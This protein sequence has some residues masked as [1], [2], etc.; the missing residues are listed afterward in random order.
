MKKTILTVSALFVIAQDLHAG[1]SGIRRHFLS[2]GPGAEP[3][4][5]AETYSASAKGSLAMYYNPAGLGRYA[6]DVAA[7]HLFLYDGASYNFFG[8]SFPSLDSGFGLGIIQLSRSGIIRRLAIDDPGIG[9]ESNQTAYIFGFSRKAAK[10]LY[11]GISGTLISM[12]MDSLN[13]KGFAGD[14]GA[15]YQRNIEKL[16]S[17]K[18]PV[19]SFGLLVKNFL[20]PGLKLCEAKEFY[21]TEF[22]LGTSFKFNTSSKYKY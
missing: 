3:A 1:E 12:A 18:D 16:D 22:R 10:G 14:F 19:L 2:R 8:V 11:A 6:G 7:E 20:R 9:I 15:Q 17:L 5:L 4:G 13:A 21:P